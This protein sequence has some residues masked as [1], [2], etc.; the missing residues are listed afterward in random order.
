MIFQHAF[1]VRK[2][3]R[4]VKFDGLEPWH[5]ED[6]KEIVAPE[7]GS[8]S[9]GTF[10]KQAPDQVNYDESNIYGTFVPWHTPAAEANT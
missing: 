8:K 9:Y 1:T 10:E 2:P 7:M 3:K 5:Y 4:N 6:I